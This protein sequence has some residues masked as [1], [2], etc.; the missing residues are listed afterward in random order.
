MITVKE[1]IEKLNTCDPD[2]Y[3]GFYNSETEDDGIANRII[4]EVHLS[5]EWSYQ[6]DEYGCQGDSNIAICLEDDEPDA[7]FVVLVY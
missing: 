3:V 7:K 5:E 6:L 4:P 1:L 2:A